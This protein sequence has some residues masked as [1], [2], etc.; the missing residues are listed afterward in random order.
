MS[1]ARFEDGVILKPLSDELR[2]V[3]QPDHQRGMDYSNLGG[4]A[5]GKVYPS[6][7]DVVR[8]VQ[9]NQ[10]YPAALAHLEDGIIVMGKSP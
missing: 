3:F 5:G 8:S 7:A 4:S 1:A 10:V 9:E 2:P 6:P